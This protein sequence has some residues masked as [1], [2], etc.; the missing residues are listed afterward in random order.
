MKISSL[1]RASMTEGMDVFNMKKGGKWT[2]I[3][4]SAVILLAF[5]GWSVSIIFLL[6]ATNS[7]IAILPM[8]VAI[9]S[10]LTLI[11]GV[12]KS[13]GLLFNCRDDDMLLALPI[14][15]WQIVALR[16]FKFYIFEMAFNSL[17][18]LPAILAYGIFANPGL[19][20]WPVSLMMILML[21]IIPVTLS[22]VIGALI[23]ALS[24]RF[25]KNK[26]M[27]TFLAFIFMFATMFISLKASDF[28]R[29]I[30]NY[31]EGIMN[32]I[33]QVYYPARVYTELTLSFDVIKLVVFI[34]AHLAVAA[35]AVMFI[36]AMY[37]RVNS[38]VKTASI[39]SK[40]I[41][42]SAS[43]KVRSPFFALVK[44]EL[45]RFFGTPVLI[46]NSSFGLILFLVGV[47]IACWKFGDL[48]PIFSGENAPLSFDILNSFLPAAA[49]ALITFCVLMTNI[50]PA[51][52]S[53]EGKAFNLTKVLPISARKL[54]LA[55]VAMSFV[56]VWPPILI[57]TVAMIIR[58]HFGIVESLML[59]ITGIILPMI[60]GLFGILVDLKHAK[61]DAENDTE[62]V[63]QG[64]STVIATFT[65]IGAA[66]VIIGLAIFLMIQVGQLAMFAIVNALFTIIL[67]LLYSHFAK[68]CEKKFK[69]LQV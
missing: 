2:K 46:A 6:R 66:M 24:S 19:W 60:V 62:V 28:T 9:T 69:R 8:F 57:G 44:K 49:F 15:R 3:I 58:F 59:I 17:F 61:F 67:W 5:F 39:S 1:V 21:P 64:N 50:T 65:G 35:L 25:K 11:E 53:I 68:V 33:N 54:L 38:R 16:I 34:L 13:G 56:I 18:I 55:K 40:R 45:N 27:Q 43:E 36:S 26:L 42:S 7:E 41:K 14:K 30:A 48:E 31:A 10:L 47:G 63:K 4:L 52:I 37:F 32:A 22:C 20:F 51:M 29:D 12:Y 23:S